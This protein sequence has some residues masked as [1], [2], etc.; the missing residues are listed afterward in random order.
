VLGAHDHE[1][2]LGGFQLLHETGNVFGTVGAFEPQNCLEREREARCQ[3][4][5][6][7][8]TRCDHGNDRSVNGT[9]VESSSRY[10]YDRDT[11]SSGELAGFSGS[12][13]AFA[14]LYDDTSALVDHSLSQH[15]EL[16]WS[17][18][19]RHEA[20]TPLERPG[21]RGGV[22]RRRAARRRPVECANYGRRDRVGIRFRRP[23]GVALEGRCHALMLVAGCPSNHGH[24][25][26]FG[27]RD[28]GHVPLAI[29]IRQPIG[30]AP[31]GRHISGMTASEPAPRSYARPQGV[32]KDVVVGADGTVASQLALQLAV[33]LR[34][35]DAQLLALSVAEVQSALRAGLEAGNW[36]NWLRTAAEEIRRECV[37]ELKDIPNATARVA[38]GRPGDILLDA[39]RS[40]HADL[41]AI[42][43]GRSGRALGFIFGSTATRLAAESPCSVLVGR[44][45]VDL[46]RFP[47]RIAVGVD[48]SPHAADAEAV[49]RRL[50]TS[51]DAQLRRVVATGGEAIDP[52]WI[53]AGI[54]ERAPIEALT[55]A[56]READLLIVGSRGRSGVKALGSV[57]ERL[58][59]RAACPVLIVRFR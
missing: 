8:R 32:F 5:D 23:G 7:V 12:A 2:D 34:A 46:E 6:R 50:A 56:S 4:G 40:R 47:H 33:R 58:A 55:A 43:A 14:R 15:R 53:D 41:L 24:K 39:V 42:G 1:P 20:V 29:C 37:H 52:L 18:P 45:D 21:Q 54:D 35:D 38:N 27:V 36:M 3:S 49:G 11:R 9:L 17:L 30:D 22:A 57:A 59:H 19:A 51:F 13:A 48:G 28:R 16:E 44:G 25:G 26:A 31:C 10:D